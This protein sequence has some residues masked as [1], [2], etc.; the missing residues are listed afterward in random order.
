MKQQYEEGLH[1]ETLRLL[2][3]LG[4]TTLATTPAKKGYKVP[5]PN[6][7]YPLPYDNK[8]TEMSKERFDE[9]MNKKDSFIENGK[10][11][12]YVDKEGS[13]YNKENIKI[14]NVVEGVIEYIN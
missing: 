7:Y 8:P 11:R 9:I 1:L 4:I 14:G 10:L 6:K 13:L 12:G 5:R 2:R 3:H